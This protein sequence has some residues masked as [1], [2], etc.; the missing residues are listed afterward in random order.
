MASGFWI[1]RSDRLHLVAIDVDRPVV[2]VA[3]PVDRPRYVRRNQIDT[4]DRRAQLSRVGRIE[5]MVGVEADVVERQPLDRAERDLDV[6]RLVVGAVDASSNVGRLA[7]R[8]ERK[9]R[10]R[11]L[12]V[13]PERIEISRPRARRRVNRAERVDVVEADRR[14]GALRVAVEAL[15][16]R[17]TEVGQ[18]DRPILDVVARNQ[19]AGRG[20]CSTEGDEQGHHR[21]EQRG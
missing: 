17:C 15:L 6:C 14:I 5:E 11:E 7:R 1:L 4:G 19:H 3:S 10:L 18:A 9:N 8:I 20:R 21:D 16:R 12:A 13:L 2:A